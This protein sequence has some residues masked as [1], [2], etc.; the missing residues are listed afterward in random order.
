LTS[1]GGNFSAGCSWLTKR[2]T[3]AKSLGLV[4]PTPWRI[5]AK[6]R[7]EVITDWNSDVDIGA[8]RWNSDFGQLGAYWRRTG[9][10]HGLLALTA[11]AED[12]AAKPAC[13]AHG[14]VFR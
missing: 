4:S 12:I 11:M 1:R 5:D 7:I 8:G 10:S 9:A 14:G 2:T 6:G 3:T 13:P